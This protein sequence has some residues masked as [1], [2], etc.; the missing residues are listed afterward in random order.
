MSKIF[1]GK[2]ER[3][4]E[5]EPIA[6]VPDEDELK[7]NRKRKLQKRYGSSGRAGTVLAQGSKLG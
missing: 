5:P 2:Q 4:A 6:P 3:Q 7:I 1:G